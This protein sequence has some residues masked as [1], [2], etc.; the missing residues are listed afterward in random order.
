M[1]F[2]R[3]YNGLYHC[4]DRFGFMPG[5]GWMY[6]IYLFVVLVIV[7]V[8]LIVYRSR[9]SQSMTSIDSKAM[10]ELKLL[11]ARGDISEEEYLRRKS[12]L[13]E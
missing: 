1:F 7:A 5:S 8:V 12:I 4:F 6:L 13:S 3:G 9:R 10:E 11:F 2:G